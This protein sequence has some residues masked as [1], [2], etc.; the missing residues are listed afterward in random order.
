MGTVVGLAVGY[1][2]GTRTD[3]DDLDRIYR[4]VRSLVGTDEFA[5][6]VSAVR[7]HAAHL[8]HEVA[9]MIEGVDP[10]PAIEEG[11]D[12]VDRVRSIFGGP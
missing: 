9:S 8:L 6:L 3:R 10:E 4:S 1:V 2:M 12:L 11:T 5:D 7:T